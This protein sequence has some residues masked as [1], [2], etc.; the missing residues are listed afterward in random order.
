MKLLLVRHA[1][2]GDQ[3]EFAKTGKPD[4]LRPLS[5]KGRAQMRDV[6]AALR[7]LVPSPD[8]IVASPYA[9]AAQTEDIVSTAYDERI[10]RETTE[11]LAPE[12]SPSAFEAWLRDYADADVVIA[13]GHEPHLGLL[14][15]WLMTGAS[16]SRLDFKKAGA[17]LLRFDGPARKGEGT[18][19]WLMGPKELKAL[20]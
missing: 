5:A 15:T 19:R 8:L 9:R 2:A 6:A 13:V 4:E 7:E 1:D 3:E 20:G 12:A 14:A 18:L 11:T 17:C 10:R 16:E